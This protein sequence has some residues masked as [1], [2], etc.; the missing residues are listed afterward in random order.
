VLL[1]ILV[2]TVDRRGE[3][4]AR[5]RHE[6]EAQIAALDVPGE[7]E[8]LWSRD[9]G[10]APVGV[11]RNV[12]VRGASGRYVCFVDDDD[13]VDA[14]YV[15][16][17]VGALVD[18]PEVDCVGL[19]VAMSFRGRHTHLMELSSRHADYSSAGGVYRRPAHHLNPVRREIALRHPFAAV[20]RHED[21]DWALRVAAAGELRRERR[22]EDVLY[23]YAS[24]RFY[25]WQWLLDRTERPRHAAGIRMVR[26]VPLRE[27]AGARAYAQPRV[28]RAAQEPPRGSV[29]TATSVGVPDF[30]R[31]TS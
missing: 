16:A 17:I 8:L 24:R 9:D 18:G 13:E 2:A 22:V 21:Q 5:L 12:L 11:K 3:L 10:S 7:V 28:A 29:S 23:R 4:F 1:S 14:S 20:D 27:A 15:A 30:F 26:L 19:S 6:L 31:T 25:G